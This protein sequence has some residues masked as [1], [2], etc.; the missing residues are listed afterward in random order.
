MRLFWEFFRFE[1]RFRLKS[2]STYVYFAIWF[3]FSF[4]CIASE[5]FGPIAAG[6]GKVLLNGPFAN[7]YNDTFACF[8]G[9][10]VIAAIFGTSILRDF[11]RDT[12]QIV[13]TKPITK[14]AYLG[15]RWAGSFVTTVC[16]FSG[17]ILGEMAGTLR[18]ADPTRLAPTHLWW[19]FQP[20]LS[21]V[22]VQIFLTG[23]LFFT[24]AALTRRIFIVYLQGAALFMLYLMGMAAFSTTRAVHL[25]WPGVFDPIGVILND[26]ITRYWTVV[27]KNSQLYSWSLQPAGGVFVYNR[28]LWIGV[29]LVCLGLLGRFFPMSLEALTARSSRRRARQALAEEDD[30]QPVRSRAVARIPAV[31]QAFGSS[32]SIAQ[33]KSL[34]R[35]RILNVVRDIPFWV[36]CVLLACFALVNGHFAGR[37]E[38]IDV[39]PV[40]YLMLQSVEGNA[41]LFLFIVATFYAGELIWRERDTRFEGIHDALPMA[42]ATDWLSKLTALSLVELAMLTVAGLC[43]IVMQT[44]AG[45][46]HYE[47]LQYFEELYLITFS[48]VL[49]FVLFALFVQTIVT[50][51]F[52]GHAIVVGAFLA[53]ILLFNYG[54]ENTLYLFGAIPPYTYSDMNGYGH[55]VKPLFWATV[56]WVSISAFL[57]VL[58]IGLARRGAETSLKARLHLLRQNAVHIAPAAA[59]FLLLAIGSGSWFYYNTHVLNEYLNN[60]Q[61]REI[62]ADYE[63]SFKRYEHLPQPK[64]LEVD[65]EI[66]LLPESRSFTGTGHYLLENK[67]SGPIGEIHI[68]NQQQ[69]VS[70][71]AFDRPFHVQSRSPR[72]L[73]VIY[74][75]DK[76]L[77]PG[78]TINMTFKV[79]K[80]SR[81]FNDG[82]ERAELAYNGTFIDAG[83]F[84]TIGYDQ[85]VEITDPR[86]R[87][88]EHL[89][90]LELLPARGDKEASLVN[91]FSPQA[92][93]IHYRTTVSTSGD[94]IALSPGYLVKDWKAN[95]RHYFTYDMGEVEMADFFAYISGAYEVTRDTYQGAQGPIA[96][97]I[98]HLPSHK[99]DVQDM[100]DSSKAGLAFYE[101]A[102]SPFQF[103][104][105]RIIEFPRYRGFAQSFPNTVPYSES[106]GFIE[107]MQKPTDID[108]TYFVTAHELAHQ[109]WGHQL[110]GGRV[111]GSNMMS[112]T[113][114]EYS[115]LMTMRHKYGDDNMHKFLKYELDRYL[116]GRGTESRRE[117]ALG[118]V[119]QEAY[120][121]YQKGG[122][123]MYAL[124]DY[125]GEDKLNLALKNFLMQYRYANAGTSQSTPYPDTRQLIAELRAQTPENLHYFIDDSFENIVLYDNRIESAKVTPTA[126]H[127][128]KVTM[129]V[130][131][132]KMK[133]DGSGNETPMKVNDLVDIGVFTGSKDEEKPLYLQKQWVHDGKQTFEVVVDKMPS[134]AGIDPLN[135]L[136]DR[137]GDDNETDV[138]K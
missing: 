79:S 115:A 7:V 63:K 54:W 40:T 45:Y 93:W 92:D 74:A 138:S 37:V 5:N 36:L 135:K 118:Q 76:P 100:I 81:G 34:T 6:N 23:T 64:V 86:R 80:L 77:A 113:L 30:A 97:E 19:Y 131:S 116:R 41:M 4:F 78:E 58:S 14:F 28:L 121:W 128:Y 35:L 70:A 32:T 120:V 31:H 49:I 20:F 72:D 107:R 84:P 122:Q 105:F 9:L 104:Q 12:T 132:H 44:V 62:Q 126:D 83:F 101:K 91:L 102:F 98:Y 119:Q 94:Q 42:E 22:I 123:I 114:A 1:I 57:G 117:E 125:I 124:S 66:D 15:G 90:E 3:F 136:I 46:F 60:K 67:T 75:L 43:G 50:N 88:E 89:G 65:S 109:W 13:F 16:I 17:L 130:E 82:H 11:Q 29:G 47:L 133:S 112:E 99:F 51:K 56:Y 61:R 96:I 33:F 95:G 73:Y 10:I 59:V 52:I 71:V 127:K 106:I 137:N 18:P 2:I 110:I 38:G 87:R 8:F 25:F 69:S 21:I 129:V 103:R 48:Q 39:W 111:A 85:G 27:E 108:F 26:S 68:T 53:Q 24:V 55:F 134:R